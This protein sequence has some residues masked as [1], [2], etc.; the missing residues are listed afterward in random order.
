VFYAII[1]IFWVFLAKFLCLV[2]VYKRGMVMEKWW[3]GQGHDPM[4]CRHVE[5]NNVLFQFFICFELVATVSLCVCEVGQLVK[6]LGPDFVEIL[7]L[8]SHLF[9][10]R[11]FFS[12]RRPPK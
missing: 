1:D 12:R 6:S 9:F 3:V 2:G 4:R 10:A 11:F 7:K 8:S 5:F